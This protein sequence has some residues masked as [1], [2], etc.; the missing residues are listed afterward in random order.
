MIKPGEFPQIDQSDI[1]YLDSAASTLKHVDAVEAVHQ[2]YRYETANIH[3]G[4]HYLSEINTTKYEETRD[5]VQQLINAPKREEIIFTKGT[6]ESINLVARTWGETNLKKGDEI[7]ISAMEHHSN[8]VPWQL[9][10][11]RTGAKLKIIPINKR[12]EIL[13]DQYVEMLNE[14]VKLI[15]VVMISNA[16]GT[17]N[18][19]RQMI[20]AARKKTLAVF[21]LDAAQA[22]AHTKIDVQELGCDFMAF[23]AHKMFAPTGVGVLYGNQVIL[24]NMPPYLGG[25][26]MIDEVSF[27]KTTY[28]TLPHKFEAG[29]PHIAGVIGFGAAVKYL[30]SLDFGEVERF[31]NDLLEYGTQRL[32]D[33]PGLT[34][35]GT[36]EKKASIL[37]FVIDGL[38][39][40]DVATLIDKYKIAVRTGHHCTQPLMKFFNVPATVRASLSIYNTKNDIDKLAD[41]LTKIKEM[42]A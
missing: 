31:E 11:E 5:L 16:L 18:P 1:I 29:T 33:I 12:G 24:E 40:H 8:I 6:T 35:I 14:N 28:N 26:D 30:L 4:I 13:F 9:L 17:I 41:G 37:S 22:V 3:R 34:L 2:Y 20:K 15:S 23:S 10:C 19:V 39:A 36:A 32:L 27:E 21:M 7:L 38:H 25:G 42:F